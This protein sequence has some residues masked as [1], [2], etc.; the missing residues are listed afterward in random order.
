M[1]IA[2]KVSST[3][4]RQLFQACGFD[5]A[6]KWNKQ[7]LEKNLGN[8]NKLITDD[9]EISDEEVKPLLASLLGAAEHGEQIELE[10]DGDDD[11]D[12]EGTAGA[13]EPAAEEKPKE[14]KKKE[15]PVAQKD[16]AKAKA[17]KPAKATKPE[18][19]E[20]G[21]RGYRIGAY[22]STSV[23]HWMSAKGY[24]FE[25]CKKV[26]KHFKITEVTDANLRARMAVGRDP[27][28]AKPANLNKQEIAD[29]K[30]ITGK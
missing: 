24:E 21:G 3:A 19:K 12:P 1:S 7:I 13:T 18:K 25:D 23:I 16:K 28:R 22:S 5:T 2:T 20:G 26:L 27:K 14:K 9:T 8:I 10:W 15:K 4:L 11:E 29:L 30:K 6:A 17:A